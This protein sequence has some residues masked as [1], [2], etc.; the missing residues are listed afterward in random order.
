MTT[1]T[2]KPLSEAQIE[3]RRAGGRARAAQASFKDAQRQ[4]GLTRSKQPDFVEAC[5]KGFA[6]TAERHPQFARRLLRTSI[7]DFNI[8]KAASLGISLPEQRRRV[9]RAA[10][11]AENAALAAMQR[12][13]YVEWVQ[14]H[15]FEAGSLWA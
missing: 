5:R 15:A 12:A 3:A 11:V 7:K 4:G 6:T 2:K 14:G 8:A 10:E 13:A 9:R 1:T